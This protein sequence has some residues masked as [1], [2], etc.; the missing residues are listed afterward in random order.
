MQVIIRFPDA[1]T[2]K[3]ALGKLAGRFNLK[4]WANGDTMVPQQALAYL[5]SERVKYQ[6]EGPA[7]YEHLTPLRTLAAA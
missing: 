1:E 4:T 3:V 5:A 7:T 2:E 6:V